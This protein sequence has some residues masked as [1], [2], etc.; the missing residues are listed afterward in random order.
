MLIWSLLLLLLNVFC[1]ATEPGIRVLLTK[2][3]IDEVLNTWKRLFLKR[4]AYSEPVKLRIYGLR[5]YIVINNLRAGRIAPHFEI[6]ASIEQGVGFKFSVSRMNIDYYGSLAPYSSQEPPV[7]MQA[8]VPELSFNAV[9]K[10]TNVNGV[11]TPKMLSC[12]ASAPYSATLQFNGAIPRALHALKLLHPIVLQSFVERTLCKHIA[13]SI[14][15]P[16]RSIFNM[17]AKKLRLTENYYL[18]YSLVGNPIIGSDYLDTAYNGEVYMDRGFKHTATLAV[19]PPPLPADKNPVQ[20]AAMVHV[21]MSNYTLNTLLYSLYRAG[22]FN[23]AVNHKTSPDSFV[24]YLKTGCQESQICAGTIF[25]SLGD[26]YPNSTLDMQI[27]QNKAPTAVFKPGAIEI[28]TVSSMKGSVRSERNRQYYF[29]SAQMKLVTSVKRVRVRH[30]YADGD[31]SFDQLELTN[32]RSDVQGIDRVTMT[33]VVSYALDLLVK[34]DMQR[35]LKGGMKIPK[36]TT[37]E[38]TNGLVTVQPDR[39]V[40][41]FQLC[42]Q[43]NCDRTMVGNARSATNQKTTNTYDAY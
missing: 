40:V 23:M 9:I 30:Y 33:F 1:N 12:D 43:A 10:V 24:N 32:V 14:F 29:F 17:P 11:L 6:K 8:N 19:Q 26:K 41:S 3:G 39:L 34:P 21:L 27:K 5:D 37:L 36:A 13:T 20:H 4:M 15:P 31:I 25:P 38:M 7:A 2:T 16:F 18:D 35:K 28:Y 42:Y 22:K